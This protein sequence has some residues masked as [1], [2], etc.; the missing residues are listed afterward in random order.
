MNLRWRRFINIGGGIRANL[1]RAGIGWSWGIPGF[2]VGRGADGSNWISIG[3][4]GTGLYFTKRLKRN[5]GQPPQVSR[6][7]S[8]GETIRSQAEIKEWKDLR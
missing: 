6:I 8:E 4:P 5:A 1:S 7:A 3:I 2:R